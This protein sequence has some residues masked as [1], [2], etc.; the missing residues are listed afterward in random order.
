[1]PKTVSVVGAGRI[2]RPVIAHIVA[3]PDLALAGVL[4]RS[5]TTG[6]SDVAAFLALPTDIIIDTAGPVWLRAHGIDA[7]AHSD[8][9]T[10]GGAALADDAFHSA[11][12]QAATRAGHRVRLFSDWVVGADHVAQGSGARLH[13]RQCRPGETWSGTVREAAARYPDTVNSA[14]SAAVVGPGLDAATMEIADSDDG[15]RFEARLETRFG[16]IVST[17]DFGDPAQC[18]PHPSAAALIGALRREV[19]PI[20]YG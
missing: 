11:I 1:M 2:G 3:N 15:Q 4:T 6:M 13:M 18:D 8:V 5:G 14:V 10:V 17:L 12:E 19:S 16:R 20:Q 7:I 9:W